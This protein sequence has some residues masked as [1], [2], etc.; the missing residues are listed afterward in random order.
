MPWKSTVACG[1]LF[2]TYIMHN[3]EPFYGWRD[4]YIVEEDERSPFFGHQ[5]NEFAYDQKIYN[6][7]VHPQWNNF[8]SNTL[9]LKCLYTDYELGYTIIE[10]IGEWNDFLHN[11]IEMLIRSIVNPLI[12]QGVFRFI[13]IGE[14][15]LTFHGEAT[16][17]YEE[18]QDLASDSGGFV[19]MINLQDH[20]REEMND[21]GVGQCL[22]LDGHVLD[23][24]KYPPEFLLRACIQEAL[25]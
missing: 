17:Y 14:N 6:Y 8:G 18:W 22:R 23:W 24:R 4:R 10:F 20:V 12:A 1:R 3:I 19:T 16:D 7:Y 13:L 2:N 11:D 9:L 5:H 15:I 25:E 21:I